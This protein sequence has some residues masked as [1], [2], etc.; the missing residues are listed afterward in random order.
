MKQGLIALACLFLSVVLQAQSAAD[1]LTLVNR[2]KV[3]MKHSKNLD[4]EKVMSFIHPSLFK[5]ATKDQLINV[6]KSA[7]DSEEMSIKF[8]SMAVTAISHSLLF[9]DSYYRRVD[10]YAEMTMQFLKEDEDMD[11]AFISFMVST[12]Q[13]QFS[14]QKVLYNKDKKEYVIKGLDQLLA[15]KDPQKEWMF[16]GVEKDSPYMK[17]LIPENV[18]SHFKLKLSSD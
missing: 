9:S 4:F 11:S 10:Y 14:D 17:K 18:A 7:Y 13:T 3:Y 8:D 6:M 2:L 15:I 16:L 5:L 12:L 1:S